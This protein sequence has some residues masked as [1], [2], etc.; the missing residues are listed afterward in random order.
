MATIITAIKLSTIDQRSSVVTGAWTVDGWVGRSGTVAEDFVLEAGGCGDDVL[1]F[2]VLFQPCFGGGVGAGEDC[3]GYN[4]QERSY[5]EQEVGHGVRVMSN[6]N[7]T[8]R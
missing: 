5:V 3:V 7:T 2:R 4:G 8:D 6:D 1:L